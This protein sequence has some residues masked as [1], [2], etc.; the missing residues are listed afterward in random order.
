MN[1]LIK[2]YSF[3]LLLTAIFVI[4]LSA[5]NNE[6]D[7]DPVVNPPTPPA[8]LPE[9]EYKLVWE[10]NF[11]GTELDTTQWSYQIGTGTLYGL[12]RWGN[13]E[14]QYYTDRPENV[15]VENG[16]LIITALE[17]D[18]DGSEF[19]SARLRTKDKA[20][21]TF[22][23]FEFRAKM[24][25]GQGLWPAL[26]M[27]STDEVFGTWPKSGEID[28]MELVGHEPEITHGTIHYG[29][30]WPNNK[31][32]TRS[33]ALESGDFSDDFHVFTIEWE[34]N[35]IQWFL[36]GE[37]FYTM[38]SQ[39]IRPDNWPFNQKFHLLVNVAVGGNWPGNPDDTTV[40]PQTMEIDYI[41]VYQLQ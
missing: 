30:D 19:T 6:S 22:G 27:L 11:D 34:V 26:W 3:T 40:F 20:D 18:F 1:R 31:S 38:D 21:W 37:L 28:V 39:S 17:E 33:K 35:K 8:P 25:K 15:K 41:K 10:D 14:L 9:L 7:P 2:T 29:P 32:K 5:C 23:K 24:P 12:D 13:N 36:D 16:S 4:S